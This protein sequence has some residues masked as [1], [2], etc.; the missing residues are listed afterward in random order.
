MPEVHGREWSGGY[1][2]KAVDMTR[3]NIAQYDCVVIVTD[4]KAFDYAA[5]LEEADLIVDTRN[6]IKEPHPNVFKLGAP[7]AP[8]GGSEG[9]R[10]PEVDGPSYDHDGPVLDLGAACRLRLR[11]A[12]RA[13]WRSGP[14]WSIGGRG[15]R[16]SRPARWPSISIVIAARNEAPR[17]R[18]RIVNLLEQ[19]YPGRARDHRRV[20]RLDRRSGG[21]RSRAFGAAV[22]LIEVPAGGKPLA[23]NAGVAA[24]TG[25][26]LVFADARQRFAPGALTALV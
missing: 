8:R 26:I 16:R 14:G 1:D 24:A 23:L 20:R 10:S 21:A 22:R 19:D 5:L 25:E 3:G 9:R 2:I 12:I 7:R 17:L 13:C 11:R 4:H 15:A 18:A 6:A